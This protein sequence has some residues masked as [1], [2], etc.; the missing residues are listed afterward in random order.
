[1]I[2]ETDKAPTPALATPSTPIVRNLKDKFK[3]D[4]QIEKKLQKIIRKNEERANE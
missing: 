1:M 4:E 2:S 3:L